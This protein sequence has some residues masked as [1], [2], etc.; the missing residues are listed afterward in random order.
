MSNKNELLKQLREIEE[1]EAEEK[2]ERI[3]EDNYK[4]F[5]N[6]RADFM[7]GKAHADLEFCKK[8]SYDDEDIFPATVHV[9]RN[10]GESF[11]GKAPVTSA[12]KT[13]FRNVWNNNYKNLEYEFQDELNELSKKYINKVCNNL[14]CV[15]EMMGLQSNHYY[16]SNKFFSKERLVEVKKDIEDARA[17]LL[18]K[19]SDEDFL[20]LLNSRIW[21]YEDGETK[22]VVEVRLSHSR[23]ILYRYIFKHRINISDKFSNTEFYKQ[24]KKEI[25]L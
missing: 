5:K 12:T 10:C 17:E 7:I 25:L 19:Y 14:V 15:L 20:N 11:R 18:N 2:E 13:Y 9:T 24:C 21:T 4:A 6:R 3:K 1:K 16:V 23:M 8:Y 22:E